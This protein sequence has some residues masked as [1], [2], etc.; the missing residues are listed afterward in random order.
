[1][2]KIIFGVVIIIAIAFGFYSHNINNSVNIGNFLLKEELNRNLIEKYYVSKGEAKK[3]IENHIKNIA[4][5]D[6]KLNEWSKYLEEIKITTD[7]LDII[8]DSKDELIISL[9]LAKNLGAVG[10]YKL[11]GD[12]YSLSNKIGDLTNIEKIKVEKNKSTGQKLLVIEEFL[13][14]RIGAYFVDK[15]T[16]IF[17]EVE[18]DFEEV[19]RQSRNY[20]AYY[21]E[22]WINPNKESSKWYKLNE[23]GNIEY[24]FE[25]DGKTIINV[26]KMLKKSEGIDGTASKIPIEFKEVEKKDFDI[27]YIWS[28]EHK[29]FIIGK[30]RIIA[31]DEDVAIL[32]DTSKTVDYLLNLGDK[33]YKV[34]NKNKEIKYVKQD[35]INLTIDK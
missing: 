5:R 8:G 34:I 31:T 26:H 30:G 3:Q 9:N 33:Y 35:E 2:K 20:E 10:I 14:E 11:E 32:E 25:K 16:R 17:V 24:E 1:M 12:N 22:K 21:Y 27:K 19:F 18:E 7:H 23:K 28:E 29:V 4:I 13:D 15:F 6:M